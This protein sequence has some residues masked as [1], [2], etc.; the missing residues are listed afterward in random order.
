MAQIG[1][2]AKETEPSTGTGK[3][4]SARLLA[5]YDQHRRVLPWRALPGAITDPYRVWLSEIMLQQT[6]VQAVKPYF[7][8]F[9]TR[10]PRLAD[11]ATA[12][13]QDI[14]KAWAGLGYYSRARNL[15][16]CARMVVERHQGRFP[17]DEKA[18]R[19][20][21]GIGSYTA[22]AIR[23]IAFEQRAVVVDGN[24]DRVITRL[25]RID[26]PVAPAK[27]LI[28]SRAD[29]MTPDQRPG[30]HAQAMMD[31]GATICTPR[32]PACIICPLSEDCAARRAGDAEAYPVKAPKSEK[33][34]R[35]GAAFVAIC[36]GDVLVRTRPPKGLLGGMT[37]FPGTEWLA[38]TTLPVTATGAPFASDWRSCGSIR[39]VFTHFALELAVFRADLKARPAFDGQWVNLSSLD[40][41]ALPTVMRKVAERALTPPGPRASVSGKRRSG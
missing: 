40:T 1:P 35:T 24:V 2:M 19:A 21:P 20:L 29:W 16:A 36:A 5:W 25:F 39:H 8:T 37:E 22:A 30:D 27:A 9:T 17:A 3:G 23:S 11:L 41:E 4:A 15:L 33:P 28:R 6:T 26:Q 13:D 38:G 14:M 34:H 7:E 12:P 31:L 10:W 18:L 32:K